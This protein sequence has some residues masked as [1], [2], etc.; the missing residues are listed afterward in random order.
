M[1]SLTELLTVIDNI[2]LKYT[3]IDECILDNIE[4]S[5]LSGE[6]PFIYIF[7]KKVRISLIGNEFESDIF[8]YAGEYIRYLF[9]PHD[10]DHKSSCAINIAAP[11]I[12]ELLDMTDHLRIRYFI[13]VPIKA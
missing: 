10:S 7:P 12:D 4:S 5:H 13:D 11:E 2:R 8:S 9:I 6:R 3:I 1:F